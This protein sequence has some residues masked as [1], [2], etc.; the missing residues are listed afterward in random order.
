MAVYS[1]FPYQS[2]NRSIA[3]NDITLLE[4][5]VISA[6]GHFIKNTDLFSRYISK[7]LKVCPTKAVV[8]NGNW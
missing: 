2:S 3:V 8:R 7:S 5:W 6:Q 4:S 1:W